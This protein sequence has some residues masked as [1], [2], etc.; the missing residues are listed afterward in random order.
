MKRTCLQNSTNTY[1]NESCE[2]YPTINKATMLPMKASNNLMH[3]VNFHSALKFLSPDQRKHSFIYA[4]TILL[5]FCFLFFSNSKIIEAQATFRLDSLTAQP[6]DS[7]ELGLYIEDFSQIGSFTLY[8]SFSQ[9]VLSWGEADNWNSGIENQNP[10]ANAENGLLVLAFAS[11]DGISLTNGKLVDLNFKYQGGTSAL[12]FQLY[13][14]VTGT[15]GDPVFPPPVFENGIVVPAITVMASAA[16]NT[17]CLGDSILISAYTS[18][19]LGTPSFVWSSIPGGFESFE[20]QAYVSPDVLTSYVVLVDDGFNQASTTLTIDVYPDITPGAVSNMLPVDFSENLSI[21]ISFSW[22]PANYATHYDLFLWPMGEP[23]GNPVLSQIAA[24]NVN[25]NAEI[26]YGTDYQ[27]RL[28]AKNSCSQTFG[29]IQQFTMRE[30]PDL[31][32]S[33]ILTPLV[34]Y[35]GQMLNIS[36][37]VN[38]SG[39][40]ST[41]NSTWTD[42]VYLSLDTIIGNQDDIYLGAVSN[43]AALEAGDSYV[44]TGEFLIPSE[45][46]GNYIILVKA[47]RSNQLLE[48]D[49]SNNVGFDQTAASLEISLPPKADLIVTSLGIPTAIIGGSSMN[50]NYQVL[51]DGFANAGGLNVSTFWANTGEIHC[52]FYERYWTD[53]IYISSDSIFNL[54]SATS[55]GEFYI[56]LRSNELGIPMACDAPWYIIPDYLEPDSSYNRIKPVIVPHNIYGPH[57][58]FVVTDKNNSVQELANNNNLKRAGP[59]EVTLKPPP[60]LLLESITPPPAS[61]SGQNVSVSWTVKNIGANAPV[62]N[63]W[64]DKIFISQL[65]TFNANFATEVGI[66]YRF[67]GTG[68]M[69]NQTYTESLTFSL[70]QG[71]S[72]PYFVYVHTDFFNDV[73]EYTFTADN[74]ARSI[75]PFTVSLAPYAD[76]RITNIELPEEIS[77]GDT[78]SVSWT[79]INQGVATAQANW[80]DRIFISGTQ[81]WNAAQAIT[82]QTKLISQSLAPGE[83]Y[84]TASNV[85][86]PV[87]ISGMVYIYLFT[88]HNNQ[89]WE[90]LFEN[91]NVAHAGSFYDSTGS[92]TPEIVAIYLEPDTTFADLSITEFIAPVTA[93][94]GES[95]NLSYT[96]SN[97]GEDITQENYWNDRVYFSNDSLWSSN[98]VLAAAHTRNSKLDVGQSYQ[99]NKTF[100]IPN[101]LSGDYFLIAYTDYTHKELSDLSFENNRMALPISI[102]L[103][104]PT[105]LVVESITTSTNLIAGQTLVFSYTVKNQGT[106]ES[107]A[108]QWWDRIYLGTAPNLSSWNV[109][110]KFNKHEGTLAANES[111]SATVELVIPSNLTGN[112]FLLVHTDANMNVYEHEQENNNIGSQLLTIS[113][114]LPSDLIITSMVIPDSLTLGDDVAISYTIKNIGQ[115]PANGSL[116]D[117]FYFSEDELFDGTIDKLLGLN[118]KGVSLFPGDSISD[119]ITGKTPPITPG[120]YFGIGRTNL[121]NTIF[122]S[123]ISN[124]YWVSDNAIHVDIEYLYLDI[125]KNFGLEQGEWHYFK[126]EV[127]EDLDLLLSLTSNQ[128]NGSNEIYIAYER[129]PALYDF[130]Y[131]Y[132]YPNSTHQQVLVPTTQEGAYFVLVRTPYDYYGLQQV[133]LL[134]QALP[135]SILEIEPDTVGQG[136]VSTFIKGAGFKTNTQFSIVNTAGEILSVG[137]ISNYKNSMGAWVKWD[138]SSVD[139]GNY[140]VKAINPDS[141]EVFYSSGITIESSS[142]FLVDYNYVAP[143]L[144]RVGANGIFTFYFQNVG[145]VDIPFVKTDITIPEYAEV[146]TVHTGGNVLKR[147]NFGSLGN[148]EM[149]DFTSAESWKYVPFLSKDLKPGEFFSVHLIVR[150]FLSGTFPVRVRSNGFSTADFITTQLILAE[151]L[152]KSIQGLPEAYGMESMLS[153]MGLVNDCH[154]W[155]DTVMQVYI[156]AG[157]WTL[158]DTIGLDL[159]CELLASQTGDAQILI[160]FDGEY[161]YSPGTSPGVLELPSISFNSGED[162][163][164]EINKYSGIAGSDP[165][166]DLIRS[167]G[168]ITINSSAL[169]PFVVRIAS[170]DYWGAANYL[171]GWHPSVDKCWPIAIAQGG[172]AGFSPDKFAVDESRFTAYNQTFGGYFTIALHGNDTLMLCF[173]AY[174]PGVG[175]DGV[176]GATGAP[177]EDGT[178][179]GQGGPGDPENGILPGNGGNGGDGGPGIPDWGIEPG[180]GAPGGD[181]GQGGVGQPGGNGGNGGAGG[182]GGTNQGGGNGGNGG[183]GGNGGNGGDGGNGGNGGSG[184]NGGTSG[185]SGGTGGTGGNTGGGGNSGG[186]GSSGNSGGSGSGFGPGNSGGGFGPG[187][188]FGP[189]G[190]GFGGPGG[191]GGPSG[192]GGMGTPPCGNNDLGQQICDYVF[193]TSGCILAG[194]GCVATFTAAGSIVPGVGNVAGALFGA[195]TCGLGIGTCING[196]MGTNSGITIGGVDLL[197]CY[198]GADAVNC[199]GQLICNA[200]VKSCDP[201]DIVGPN[202]FGEGRFIAKKDILAYTIRFEN[203]STFATAAAQRVEIRQEVSENLNPLS[204]RIAEYGFGPYIFNAP[205]NAASLFTII[206]MPDSLGYDI[207]FT[208]AI[209]VV[210]NELFWIFQTIDPTTGL[211]PTDALAGFLAIND[212]LS[213]GEG[214][215]NYTIKPHVESE[216]GDSIF[217]EAEIVFDINEPIITPRI[218]NTIDAAG[219]VTAVLPLPETSDTTNVE[220]FIA[221][222]DDALGSGI[223]T[224]QLFVSTEGEPFE[225][226]GEYLPGD[227][228]EFNGEENTE[229]AFFSIGVDNVGNFEIMK[230]YAEATILLK[231]DAFSLQG[232]VT[233]DNEDETPIQGIMIYALDENG[234]AQ[235]SAVSDYNGYYFFNALEPGTYTLNAFS[236]HQWG[237]G[238]ATDALII[239]LNTIGLYNLSEFKQMA[240]DV[241]ANSVL[242][243]TDGLLVKRRSIASIDT[244]PAGDWLLESPIVELNGNITQAIKALC[245]GDINASYLYTGFKSM[246]LNYQLHPQKEE[247]IIPGSVFN[248]LV[249]SKDALELGAINLELEF[250]A[251]SVEI[252]GLNTDLPNAM[253]NQHQ[254]KISMAWSSL[255]PLNISDSEPLLSIRMKLLKDELI[256]PILNLGASTELADARANIHDQVSFIYSDVRIIAYGDLLLEQNFP[257][258][259]T[260][261]TTIQYTIPKSGRVSLEIHNNMG[262]LIESLINQTMEVG[263]Y[264][265]DF[266]RGHLAPGIYQ[267]T[268]MLETE[269]QVLRKSLHFIIKDVSSGSIYPRN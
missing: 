151:T 228:I 55:L 225:F 165:G 240:G 227:A 38:N 48:S 164:W 69:P 60:N 261:S 212:S 37:Q 135:F 104:P 195:F 97:I 136:V 100:T 93:N 213:N 17:I 102:N 121:Q 241:S 5:G 11:A 163:L 31:N 202:G 114:P 161:T 125:P 229:Y 233:Y 40:G 101:G 223:A 1:E 132:E 123:D 52:V 133:S 238:N 198:G 128:P 120:D 51:N 191:S 95:I 85:V 176:P 18:G 74:L 108:S 179:G 90:Y 140:V 10:L 187:G 156:D 124:N 149:S 226:F 244:F 266:N 237:G 56:G 66:K 14:E 42:G 2:F 82:L 36:W 68:F 91:N 167:S 146:V 147:S 210:N 254:N 166:W 41:L 160:G 269:N 206:D 73:F 204:F 16:Y 235:D 139:E 81:N 57:Y 35:S 12:V 96:V 70:P 145:N 53:G 181:G 9:Q 144:L 250:P 77:T 131:I 84:T 220:I 119:I 248:V 258:P 252:V 75:Q 267:Y 242:N 209:D 153:L 32:V 219:P 106:G 231:P 159:G 109:P 148:I 236:D 170:L 127:A 62:E 224:Y 19:G 118:N 243:S 172:F 175:E 29:P 253:V 103:S 6:G 168:V 158:N 113:S 54:S 200:V 201:N 65:D 110:L 194:I 50:V 232:F 214:F 251:E 211:P 234:L 137:Q 218:F 26:Q 197:G 188:N 43:L 150:N 215:V 222:S 111:Y 28:L 7:I 180:N 117:A 126:V 183:S 208:A 259:F 39:L 217:A 263:S 268:L 130:D 186:S 34:I 25:Y 49:E 20:S 143:N 193:T 61:L 138:F 8:I 46:F 88:D 80:S 87:N 249:S 174:V 184:G 92:G 262:Q 169:N 59:L 86:I 246:G 255:N 178:P 94:S 107:P 141:S 122:E 45:L 221:G 112:F 230:D 15:A 76:L 67:G 30:L 4:V 63:S 23:Q 152:R 216:T 192:P 33:N 116:R 260:T 155:R 22:F 78:I 177:G 185:G 105:D 134:A 21:P 83:S 79:V 207:E 205:E 89:V 71:I 44:Q 3:L 245:M 13:C 196:L 98:D 72:G 27:W 154:V 173:N 239:S 203:D 142:G 58:V 182:Q 47:D 257:N 256:E 265:L 264:S 247:W 24:I 199:I 157:I 189:G 190:G 171:G 99:V 115:N 129:V 64:R 162:Y